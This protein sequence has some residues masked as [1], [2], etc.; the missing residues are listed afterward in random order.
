[1]VLVAAARSWQP[2]S[3]LKEISHIDAAFHTMVQSLFEYRRYIPSAC[4]EPLEDSFV[5]YS[6]SD[7]SDLSGGFK[8]RN[9][10][11]FQ[12]DNLLLQ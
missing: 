11:I 12:E 5:D 3:C 10:F 4:L 1:M 6:D 7:D 2:A 8:K 9:S